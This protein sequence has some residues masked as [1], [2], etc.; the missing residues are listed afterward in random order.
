MCKRKTVLNWNYQDAQTFLWN[1]RNWY[2]DQ[3]INKFHTFWLAIWRY[4]YDIYSSKDCS[5]I[6]DAMAE[7]ES[8]F[9][10]SHCPMLVFF[11]FFHMCPS[12]EHSIINFL[13]ANFS[14]NLLLGEPNLQ[15]FPILIPMCQIFI[16]QEILQMT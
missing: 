15:Y 7:N 6:L 2:H 8:P 12:K 4:Y 9:S 16:W 14:Q 13:H 1:T 3:K 5:K 10:F 11:F